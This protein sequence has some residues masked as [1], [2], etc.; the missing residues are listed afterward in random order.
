MILRPAELIPGNLYSFTD[1]FNYSAAI[2]V[3]PA[4]KD[5]EGGWNI[6]DEWTARVNVA[7]FRNALLCVDMVMRDRSL[8]EYFLRAK[9]LFVLKLYMCS[10]VQC[11]A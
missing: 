7:D 2:Y 3:L 9:I 4:S 1:S 11:K 10:H 6:N 8:P 5:E